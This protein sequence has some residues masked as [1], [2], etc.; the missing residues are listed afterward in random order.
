MGLSHTEREIKPVSEKSQDVQEGKVLGDHLAQGLFYMGR[1]R[2]R[3]EKKKV[4]FFFFKGHIASRNSMRFK[5]GHLLSV[6]GSLLARQGQISYR[7]LETVS[8]SP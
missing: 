3:E 7:F 2:L 8:C 4:F 6:Q 5:P 1:R